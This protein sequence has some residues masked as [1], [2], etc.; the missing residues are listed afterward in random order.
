MIETHQISHKKHDL[1]I[2]YFGVLRSSKRISS[3]IVQ[4]KL[5]IHKSAL[6]LSFPHSL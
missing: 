1:L 2:T 4:I 6:L 5:T 3:D